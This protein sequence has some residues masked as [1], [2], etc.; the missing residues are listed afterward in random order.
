MAITCPF[1]AVIDGRTR[2]FHD[3]RFFILGL[4]LVIVGANIF[5]FLPS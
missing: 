1:P 4:A 5:D 3:I 2:M